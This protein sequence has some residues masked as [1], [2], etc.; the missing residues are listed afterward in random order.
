MR[1][2]IGQHERYYRTYVD[3]GGFRL[4]GEIRYISE[5]QA[6]E[7]AARMNVAID[8]DAAALAASAIEQYEQEMKRRG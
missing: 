2:E 4:W 3:I 6:K 8:D 5:E 1:A 7:D